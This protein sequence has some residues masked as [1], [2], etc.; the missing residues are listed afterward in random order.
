MLGLLVVILI[1]R[2]VLGSLL[3]L[4]DDGTWITAVG[5]L[6]H[7]FVMTSLMTATFIFFRDRY[8]IIAEQQ[9]LLRQQLDR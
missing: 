7:A 5:I 1:I 6:G 4:A 3:V 2:N 8:R 9:N